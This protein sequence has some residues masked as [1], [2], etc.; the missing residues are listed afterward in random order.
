[1]YNEIC[2]LKFLREILKKY[3]IKLSKSLGQNFLIN[4]GICTKIVKLSQI[5]KHTGVL[6]IGPGGGV[7][8]FDLALKA[9]KVVAVEIDKKLI[10]V[11][12]Y[13]LKN[14]NNIKILKGN[15]LNIDI[16]K[17]IN[18]EFKEFDDI[19]VCANIPYYI[20]SQIIMR[21][22]EEK[23]NV[24]SIFVMVQ[25]EAA[26]RMCSKPG[27]SSC[28]AISYSVRYFS[29]PKILFN[30]SKGSFFPTPK[31]DSCLILLEIRKEPAIKVE[32]EEMF[33]KLIKSTFLERRKTIKNPIRTRMNFTKEQVLKALKESNIPSSS[34]AQE[35]S[36]EQFGVLSNLISKI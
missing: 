9:K 6:E 32:N 22:L 18:E 28:G 26:L 29:Y 11:L 7:L 36:L 30:V 10:P 33:F 14:F 5:N 12:N 2:N 34:R 4:R 23:I 19:I 17:L 27:H 8:T 20:T 16:K 25:K 15:I 35:L 21:F 13:T 24:K 31:V 1:M 3:D